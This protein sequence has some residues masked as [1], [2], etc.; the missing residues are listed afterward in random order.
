MTDP[1][2]RARLL[3][4]AHHHG[5]TEI[6]DGEEYVMITPASLMWARMVV[7]ESNREPTS[8]AQ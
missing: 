6:A 7:A 1:L 4:D 3:L 8:C 2:T 5:Y